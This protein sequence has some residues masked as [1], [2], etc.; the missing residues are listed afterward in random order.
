MLHADHGILVSSKNL[1]SRAT[2]P[3]KD[4]GEITLLS[5]RSD[6]KM[7]CRMGFQVYGIQEKTRII[8]IGK[9][10]KFYHG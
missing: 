3:W 2:K 9:R 5:E 6:L 4:M 7:L 10:S 1:K 8:K